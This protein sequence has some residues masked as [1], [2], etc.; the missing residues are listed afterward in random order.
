MRFP[1]SSPFVPLTLIRFAPLV[2]MLD[3]TVPVAEPNFADPRLY[4]MNIPPVTVMCVS[5]SKLIPPFAD[6]WFIANPPVTFITA[7]GLAIM[8]FPALPPVFNIDVYPP[9]SISDDVS[10][11]ITPAVFA[12]CSII[13][14]VE[15]TSACF[16]TVIPPLP[17][18]ITDMY[19]DAVTCA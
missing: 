18:F 17:R 14:P 1:I 5:S 16:P 11:V 8:P 9:A 4:A 2:V 7:P 13:P 12:L 19:P 6:T 3:P 10:S 15:L